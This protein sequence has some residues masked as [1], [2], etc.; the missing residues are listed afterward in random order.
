[1]EVKKGEYDT[2]CTK[3]RFESGNNLPLNK[4]LKFHMLTVIVG[5]D[6]EE[7]GK[8]YPRALLD[9]CLYEVWMLEYDRIDTSEAIDIN[10]VNASKRV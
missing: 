9:E 6:F 4:I 1:M 8:Y 2:E 10:K 3:I 5:S 7:H